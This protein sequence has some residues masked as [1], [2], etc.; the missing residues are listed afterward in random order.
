MY[1]EQILNC[2]ENPTHKGPLASA[3]RKADA[4]N[5]L[6]GDYVT[7]RIHE[8]HGMIWQAKFEGD[9]CCMM[10]GSACMVCDAIEGETLESVK[11]YT[12]DDVFRIIGGCPEYKLRWNCCLLILQALKAALA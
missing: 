12:Q 9:G 1:T 5:S 4:T 10:V 11:A 8:S 7:L 2:W 3:N 6:C